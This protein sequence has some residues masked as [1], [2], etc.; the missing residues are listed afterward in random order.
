M[1]FRVKNSLKL[2]QKSALN[3][4]NVYFWWW[5]INLFTYFLKY[6][7]GTVIRTGITYKKIPCYMRGSACRWFNIKK[8][9]I[10]RSYVKH[11]WI[12]AGVRKCR[13]LTGLCKWAFLNCPTIFLAS[14]N[15]TKLVPVF[16]LAFKTFN[17]KIR[18]LLKCYCFNHYNLSIL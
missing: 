1:K 7:Y 3:F 14:H 4:T 9:K 16:F 18:F 5:I 10:L 13:S 2:L 15:K 11:F 17:E 6:K 8:A 12:F